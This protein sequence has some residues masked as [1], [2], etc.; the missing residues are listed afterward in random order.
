LQVGALYAPRDDVAFNSKGK[1]AIPAREYV[2]SD[3]REEGGGGREGRE[4]GG[5]GRMRRTT[6]APF[7][8]T[9]SR[10]SAPWCN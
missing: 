4:A 9:N 5:G 10:A 7:Q 2:S 3:R 8:N 1:L 6:D